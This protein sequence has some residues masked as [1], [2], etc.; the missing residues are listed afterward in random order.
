MYVYVGFRVGHINQFTECVHTY[1]KKNV[2]W[3][4]VIGF[5][6]LQQSNYIE[7]ILVY[8]LFYTLVW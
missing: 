3:L 1:T 6:F 8:L 4:E 7:S 5:L 2:Y